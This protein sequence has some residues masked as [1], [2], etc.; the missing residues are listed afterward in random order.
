MNK[1]KPKIDVLSDLNSNT[2]RINTKYI[3]KKILLVNKLEEK[4]QVCGRESQKLE[5]KY[6]DEIL[7]Q[8]HR[9]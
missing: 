3:S 1:S 8:A 7:L 5:K 4:T 9:V 2:D 6:Q